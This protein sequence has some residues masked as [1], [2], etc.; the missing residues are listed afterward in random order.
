[1]VVQQDGTGG[2]TISGWP[3]YVQWLGGSAPVISGAA[4]A[5]DLVTLLSFDAGANAMGSFGQGA[6]FAGAIG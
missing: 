4:W 2:R 1:M 3:A 6:L 5:A